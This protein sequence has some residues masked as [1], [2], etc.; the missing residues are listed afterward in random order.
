MLVNLPR[1]KGTV[2]LAFDVSNSMAADDLEPTR[3]EAAKTAAR[4]FVENQPS[5]VDIGVVAFSN[6]GLVVQQPTNDQPA[7]LDTIARLSPQGATSL[8]QGIFSSLNA[9]AGEAIAIDEALLEEGAQP[10]SIGN[11]GSSVIVLL[12][13]GEN[14]EV[15]DPLEIA[16]LAAE[17][18]VRIYP[19]GI[20]S[21]EGTILEVDGFN[22]LTQLNEGTLQDIARL[23]NGIYY[24]AKDEES[25]AE[26]YE[27]IDLQLTVDGEKTEITALLAGMGMLFLL[28]GGGLSLLWFGRVP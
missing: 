7:I 1:V 9:I 18:G 25:L 5:T 24:Y 21:T 22:I 13:D 17:A 28:A 16:Q 19:V 6:G 11:Y 23:T 8:S 26:I 15:Q 4:S 3:M 12:S 14:T 20:G 2:I 27:N 10:P